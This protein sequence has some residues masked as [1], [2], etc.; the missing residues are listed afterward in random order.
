[1]KPNCF[2]VGLDVVARVAAVAVVA[3]HLVQ[4]VHAANKVGDRRGQLAAGRQ[5]AGGAVRSHYG[6]RMVLGPV[7]GFDKFLD[8]RL[9]LGPLFAAV[10]ASSAADK[11][12]L[13]RTQQAKRPIRHATAA[14]RIT[15]VFCLARHQTVTITDANKRITTGFSPN[16]QT[17]RLGRSP[18]FTK[19]LG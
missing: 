3:G 6:Q 14:N 8:D 18:L 12:S 10:L 5:M 15:E 9:A 19:S 7:L 13:V 16:V 2:F 1:M 4:I 11:S 17:P